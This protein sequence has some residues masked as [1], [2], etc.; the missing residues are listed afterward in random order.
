MN[1]P[2]HSEDFDQLGNFDQAL[3]QALSSYAPPE[4]RPG[5]ERRILAHMQAHAATQAD[6]PPRRRF[7]WLWIGAGLAT[8]TVALILVLVMIP[9]NC[10][11]CSD[12]NRLA[13]RQPIPPAI[14][15]SP[16]EVRL[17]PPARRLH[18]PPLRPVV[19]PVVAGSTELTQ[20]ERL[21]TQFAAHHPDAALDLA[22]T[23]ASL[24][25][26]IS[27]APL[28]SEPIRLQALSVQPMS[29]VPIDLTVRQPPSF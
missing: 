1:Q 13:R 11:S 4:P 21:L 23:A 27:V 26:P 29:I 15:A 20:Q 8:A 6:L 7:R 10:V 22:K 17:G 2:S 28:K 5:L 3:D 12:A 9:S 19:R 18:R 14:S 16:I 24:S 25:Q